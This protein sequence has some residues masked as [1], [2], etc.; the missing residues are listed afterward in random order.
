MSEVTLTNSIGFN[1]SG[2]GQL[3]RICGSG[4][5]ASI[6]PTVGTKNQIQFYTNST[7]VSALDT[8]A[9]YMANGTSLFLANGLSMGHNGTQSTIAYDLLQFK[10]L[11]TIVST[12]TTN[13]MQV[14]VLLSTSNTI[15]TGT[16]NVTGTTTCSS[17]NVTGTLTGN[18]TSS[19]I[20][21]AN[22]IGPTATSY[23]NRIITYIIANGDILGSKAYP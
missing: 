7:I 11:G 3:I 19:N 20:L 2:N 17:F 23:I 21:E 13:A 10:S 5:S 6:F 4:E 22:T 18:I 12:F 8:N 14:P 1:L 16:L 15:S 9:L